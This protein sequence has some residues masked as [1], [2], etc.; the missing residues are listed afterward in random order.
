MKNK[1]LS[2]DSKN[3]R[4]DS[5]LTRQHFSTKIF[6][7]YLNCIQ[8]HYPAVNLEEICECAGLPLA[9]L[10]D[11]TNWVSAAFDRNFTRE[12]IRATRDPMLPDK[13]SRQSLRPESIGLLLFYLLK[14]T[15]STAQIYRTISQQCENFTK[16]MSMKVMAEKREFVHIKYHPVNLEMLSPE[17]HA[18]LLENL[19]NIY[20]NTVGY[21]K[22]IPTIH[23]RPRAE[24]KHYRKPDANGIPEL[25]LEVAYRDKKPLPGLAVLL[26]LL[27]LPAAG[28]GYVLATQ[29]RTVELSAL[30]ITMMTSGGLMLCMFAGFLLTKFN[31]Q[32]RIQQEAQKTIE[33]MDV[34]YRELQVTKESLKAQES[35]LRK[36]AENYPNS[37]ISIIKEDF[38]I[39]FT[40]GLEYKK[41]N[42]DPNQFIGLR[43]E[44]ILPEHAETLRDLYQQ[45]FAGEECTFELVIGNRYHL[46][47]T[48]PLYA[49]DGT[50]PRIMVVSENITARKRF[51][52]SLRESEA[53]YR[54]IMESTKADV[55]ICSSDFLVE[56]MNPALIKHTG[57]DAT[58]ESC[59][60]AIYGRSEKCPWCAHKS[61]MAGTSV[62]TEVTNP[63]DGKTYHIS[64]SPIFHTDGTISKLTILHDITSHRDLERNFQILFQEMLDGFALHEIICDENGTPADYRFLAVNPAF[65]RMTGLK[66]QDVVGKTVRELLPDTEPLWIET[67]GKVALTGEPAFFESYSKALNKHFQVT[68]FQ[69]KP[70]QFACIFVDTT[71]IKKANQE[72][73]ALEAQLQQAQKM[74]A[75]GTLADGI[76]HDFNNILFPIIGYTEMMLE[77]AAEG[78]DTYNNLNEVLQSSLRARDL[79]QQILTFSRQAEKEWKPVRMHLIV[80]EVIKLIRATLPSTIT[81]EQ[82]I[83]KNTG[84]VLADPTHIHQIAMNLL[85]NAYH[86]MENNGG[87]LMISLSEVNFSYANLNGFDLNP[88]NFICLTVS[89][90]GHGID[91]G[92]IDRVF[93]PYFTTKTEGKGTGL[94]LSVVH[95]IVKSY[96]GDIRVVSEPGKGSVFT[97]YLP[98]IPSERGE[99]VPNKQ[100]QIPGGNEHILIVDDEAS[101]LRMETKMLERLGYQVTSRTSSIEAL[102][103]FRA[104]PDKFDLVITDMTMPNM[105]G[106]KLAVSLKKIRETIPVIVCTGFSEKISKKKLEALGIDDL[107]L[108]PIVR[109]DLANRIRSVLDAGKGV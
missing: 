48:V 50:I 52:L 12:C 23:D 103:A 84:M 20:Q 40:S 93:E 57:H 96:S 105:T 68:S 67:Y 6:K 83:D 77:K 89:D 71:D 11:E 33:K 26:L 16:I 72:K 8:H 22:A 107:L 4:F 3:R 85:T 101:I 15:F 49:E 61:V 81:I 10:M 37:Y 100:P 69:P 87:T 35:L 63:G 41:Q 54:S 94:G 86:A 60:K 98:T 34:Q 27:I 73:Q 46:I 36:I 90:T 43:P 14:Y 21:L 28:L 25:H 88:G 56:Y 106:D 91:K 32:R 74:Q 5:D 47:R 92:I 58:G 38:T 17:D 78:T 31:R 80:R 55:Y 7:V 102:E 39:I 97:V 51:E 18:A 108:K 29:N 2:I 62:E 44:D 42:L 109:E 59:Y 75:I 76:A 45:T 53:R 1:I 66:G 13:A 70:N 24:V 30:A 9:Y 64:N 95:G 79:V 19:D 99:F 104:S 65:E 82:H